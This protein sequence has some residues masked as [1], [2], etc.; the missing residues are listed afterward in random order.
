MKTWRS[1]ANGVRIFGVAGAVCVLVFFLAIQYTGK[2]TP[3]TAARQ[4]FAS[5]KQA[6]G[7][8]FTRNAKG[9]QD[10]GRLP[11]T[12]EENVGQTAREVRYLSRG[13]GY[14]LFLTNQEAVLALRN[15]GRLDLSPRH[16]FATILALRKARLARQ[17]HQLT[18]IRLRFEGANPEPQIVGMDEATGRVNYFFGSDPRKWHTEVPAYTRVKYASI[19]PGIDL[20]FYGNQRRLEYDFVVA[21]G[22]DPKAIRLH[23]QGAESL[24]VNANGNLVLN[25]GKGEI[26]FQKPVI[27]QEVNG[28]RR[29]IAG[30]FAVA[31][32]HRVIFNVGQYDRT[33]P[34]ILDPVLNY[35]TYLG[36]SSDDDASAIAVD[37]NNNVIIAGTTFSTDFPT[38]ANGFQTAPLAANVNGASAAF[39]TELDPTGTQLKY[40]TYLAGSTPFEF[41]FGVDVDATGMIYVTGTTVSTDFPT[42]SVITG[43]KPTS[44]ANVNGTSFITKLDPTATGASSLLYSSYIGGTD[45][46][47][48]I[49]DIGQS[50]AADQTHTGVVYVTGYTDSTAGLVT[51]TANF[52]VVGGFQTTLGS[53]NGNAFLAKIDTTVSGTGSLLYSTYVGGNAANFV[54]ADFVADIGDGVTV[55]SNSNAYLA[56]VTFS[57]D[58]ATTANAV[59]LAYPASNTTSTAFVARVDTTQN[60]ANSLVYLSY[61][62]GTGPDFGDAIA[63]GPNS[64]AY[65]TGQTKSLNFPTT[66]GAFSTTGNAT[67]VAYVTLVNTTAAA[68]SPPVYSTLLGGSGGDDGL[69]IRV[70]VKGNAYVAGGTSSID[71]PF[72]PGAFQQAMATSA[73]GDGFISKVNPGGNGKADLVYSSYFGGSA[74][75]GNVDEIE[76]I[77]IDSSN[78][79]YVAGQTFS[80]AT[81]PIFPNPGAF[82]T[83]LNGASDAFAAKLTLIPTLG[84]APSSLDFGAQPVTV[85]SAAQTITLTNNTSDPIPFANSDL[86]F[87]GSNSADFASPSN[88][89]GASIAAGVSCTVSVTF[90]PSVASAE[91]ATLV[92]T[93]TITDG[94]LTSSQQFSIGLSG[95]GS[96]AGPGVGLSQA[97]LTFGGQL[98]TT[99]SAPQTVTLTNTGTSAL[100]I[101]S[102][103]ASGDFAQTN[104][105]PLS[106]ATLAAA[107]NCTISVTFAPTAVGPRAGTLTIMDNA[108]NSPQT[109][110]LTGTGWDF[111]LTAPSTVS[112]K[113]MNSVEFDVT[114]T[115][116]GGFNQ[117]V[118]LACSVAL[119]KASCT[120]NPASVTAG[121]GVTPQT[122]D[123]NA[124][125]RGMGLM[126]PLPTT[127]TAPISMQ[128]IVPVLLALLLLSLLFTTSRLRVRLGMA[129]A[130]LL[131]LGLVG[132][133]YMATNNNA[134]SNL[135][136]ATN[137]LKKGMTTLTITGSSGGVSKSVTVT[138]TVK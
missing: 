30:G 88:T 56:G 2:S 45:G 27:Y 94:G 8:V 118:A 24:R 75:P 59:Q 110:A 3:K 127:P 124:I 85:T 131:L 133:G 115:P 73:L 61:L 87:N 105:C 92:I 128:Q 97:S 138:L 39:V 36:G 108:A 89:C 38:S 112:I 99:T 72:T 116:L 132:C 76:A 28:R 64:V 95:T 90:T 98:L 68:G 119:K 54:P 104:N 69:G 109:V 129:T 62:G 19:Y 126:T 42:G 26:E 82:Q 134:A 106:P 67:G 86:A 71:F 47:A 18:A 21:P 65:I 52:P 16:R 20:L 123:I 10:Y 31:R 14:Q 6:S 70:D 17:A 55:D 136:Q 53:A 63:L 58:L 4:V 51:D 135:D 60:G 57:T 12:F 91:S 34:L 29:E 74:S 113:A 78:N 100:T 125:L 15:P 25:T 40:S 83:S 101:N 44:P 103:A 22:A 77:A 5:T 13:S 121:D 49:G 9:F 32:N 11:L 84:V 79:V 46:T 93:V 107:G 80:S 35:S 48:A 137:G 33:E 96:A 122:A 120:A 41:A 1:W 102:I 7:P 114:M 37:A 117:A 50:A 23:V 66:S 111:T 130:V 81:F 43:F